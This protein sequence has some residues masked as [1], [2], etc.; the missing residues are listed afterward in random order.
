M[1]GAFVWRKILPR[2]QLS[3]NKD[4]LQLKPADEGDPTLKVFNQN[5]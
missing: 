2:K 3:Q 4:E 5:N 1:I